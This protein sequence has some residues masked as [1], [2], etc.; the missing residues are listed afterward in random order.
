MPTDPRSNL[1]KSVT[2]FAIVAGLGVAG[3]VGGGVATAASGVAEE[4]EDEVC[5]TD[6]CENLVGWYCDVGLL[7]QTVRCEPN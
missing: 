3:Y 4:C 6:G 2:Y 1:R 7:C 5:G